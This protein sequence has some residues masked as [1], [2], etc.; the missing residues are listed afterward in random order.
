MLNFLHRHNW[1]LGHFITGFNSKYTGDNI[2]RTERQCLNC[3]TTQISISQF[4]KEHQVILR[5][6]AK[7]SE[8]EKY[9]IY[10]RDDK[11]DK[12]TLGWIINNK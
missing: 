12:L 1:Y 2:G 11:I 9:I 7:G 6:L 8:K 10:K 4:I 5:R 3:D